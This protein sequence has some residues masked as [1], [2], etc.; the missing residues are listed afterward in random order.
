M[1]RENKKR[2]QA[3]GD[4]KKRETNRSLP[5]LNLDDWIEI[6]KIVAPQGL[7]GEMRVYPQTGN[8]TS[9]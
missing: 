2:K 6:G 1:K 3:T 7:T 9:S 5:F 8:F 4:Q